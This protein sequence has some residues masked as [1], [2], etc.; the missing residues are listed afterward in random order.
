MVVTSRWV[1][2]ARHSSCPKI[3]TATRTNF[4]CSED[5]PTCRKVVRIACIDFSHEDIGH[6]EGVTKQPDPLGN[7]NDHHGY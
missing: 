4:E 1:F 2:V 5:H 3:S 6:L 7:K